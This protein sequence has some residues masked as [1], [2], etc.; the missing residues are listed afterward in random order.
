MWKFAHRINAGLILEMARLLKESAVVVFK[1]LLEYH[2]AFLRGGVKACA[3]SLAKIAIPAG[4]VFIVG[5]QVYD[6]LY[7]QPS[8]PTFFQH[9]QFMLK[10]GAPLTGPARTDDLL[11]SL[12]TRPNW[13]TCSPPMASPGTHR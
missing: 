7:T 11:K 2:T 12:L 6:S 3:Y 8:L 13:T 9:M 10:N 1:S 4:I 5:L